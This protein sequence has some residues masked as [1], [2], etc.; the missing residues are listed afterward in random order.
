MLGGLPDEAL[1]L[2]SALVAPLPLAL[3]A[4]RQYVGQAGGARWGEQLRGSVRPKAMAREIDNDLRREIDVLERQLREQGRSLPLLSQLADMYLHEG[5]SERALSLFLEAGLSAWNAGDAEQA[6]KLLGRCLAID[7]ENRNVRG[8]IG[9]LY[10]RSGNLAE[11]RHHLDMLV[12]EY[13]AAGN[14]AAL[15]A[16]LLLIKDLTDSDSEALG[17]RL[18]SGSA[19]SAHDRDPPV[20]TCSF[21]GKAQSE[22]RKLIA[23]RSA[24]ICDECAQLAYDIVSGEFTAKETS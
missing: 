7:P 12:V 2:S 5:F 20:L 1:Q 22:V 8:K 18:A 6:A 9:S 4:E 24:Y 10:K 14:E 21:C 3:A 15:A 11:A 23:G 17:K 19:A 16:T 13:E